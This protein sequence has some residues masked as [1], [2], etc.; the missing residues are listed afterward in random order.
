MV[1]GCA[2][3]L[4]DV[5]VV[6][7]GTFALRIRLGAFEHHSDRNPPTGRGVHSVAAGRH[8]GADSPQRQ[9]AA[10]GVCISGSLDPAHAR[11]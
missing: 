11:R 8:V 10:S 9:L 6:L 3:G 5:S 2:D 7:S 1:W 4:D